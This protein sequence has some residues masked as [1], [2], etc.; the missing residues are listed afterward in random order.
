MLVPSM[1][2][3]TPSPLPLEGA[4]V[5]EVLAEVL[6]KAH[7]VALLQLKRFV[8][9]STYVSGLQIA[10]ASCNGSGDKMP[11]NLACSYLTILCV[12]HDVASMAHLMHHNFFEPGVNGTVKAINSNLGQLSSVLAAFMKRVVSLDEISNS[13]DA[14]QIEGGGWLFA[15]GFSVSAVR[16]WRQCMSLYGGRLQ[17]TLLRHFATT[18]EGAAN[19]A[20]L[21]VP[22]WEG[23]IVDGKF[24]YTTGELLLSQRLSKITRTHNELHTVLKKCNEYSTML[25]ITP[26]LP[27]HNITSQVVATALAALKRSKQASVVCAGFELLMDGCCDPGSAQRATDFLAANRKE[28]HAQDVP[29]AF[30]QE[31]ERLSE[32]AAVG[33]PPRKSLRQ[34][35]PARSATSTTAESGTMVGSTSTASSSSSVSS[36][37]KRLRSGSPSTPGSAVK[38]RRFNLPAPIQ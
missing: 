18:L 31:L 2:I 34:E 33:A 23:C 6:G 1:D 14:L 30:W 16:Q 28:G 3:M 11:S 19:S 21:A 24:C 22:G 20:S 5:D 38:L 32:G 15:S 8:S 37:A 27:H 9:A 10:G 35:S 26:K 13:A 4:S 12:V 29:Y 36:S 17:D 7:H 25:S